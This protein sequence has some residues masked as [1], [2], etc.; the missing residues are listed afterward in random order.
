M[1]LKKHILLMSLLLLTSAAMAVPAG[2]SLVFEDNFDGTSLNTSKWNYNYPW[3]TYHNHMANCRSQQVTVANGVMTITAVHERSIWDPW[4]VWTDNFGWLNFDYTSGAINTSGKFNFTH[5]YVEG[6][7][8]MP[9]STS[10]W[11]AFWM[12]E[13]GWP[14]EIDIFEVP[15]ERTR[16]YYNYHYDSG[17]HQSFGGSYVGP[18]LSSGWHTYG[19]E[20]TANQIAFYFDGQQVARYTNPSALAQANDMY[21]IINLAVGGWADFPDSADY[22]Q[23]LQCDWVRVYEYTGGGGLANGTYKITSRASGRSLDVY[24]SENAN[25]ANVIIWDYW[26]GTNQRWLVTDI[27]GGLYTIRSAMSGNRSLDVWEGGTANG[28]NVALYTYYANP[29]QKFFI[30]DLGNG[31]YR[32]TPSHATAQ[33]LDT[34]TSNG[35]NVGTWSWWG[36]NNQQWAFSAP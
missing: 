28:T 26:G 23:Q 14:P 34:G 11:P 4:G 21:L 36:G 1:D 16:Y 27:G 15:H 2:Y 9:P 12:L 30:T 19:M 7:F 24:N 25:G 10:T 32:I 31:Y 5:G 3:G 29:Q 35:A 17:G 22:P 13:S 8:K 18:N 20:W 6:R 33:C